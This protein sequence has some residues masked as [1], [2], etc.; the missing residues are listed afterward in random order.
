ML[1]T[2]LILTVHAGSRLKFPGQVGS[3]LQE[4][5]SVL[6]FGKRHSSTVP[7]PSKPDQGTRNLGDMP[8]SS[9]KDGD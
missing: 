4:I 6:N 5:A 8:L 7:A 2:D 1:V 9:L 3:A